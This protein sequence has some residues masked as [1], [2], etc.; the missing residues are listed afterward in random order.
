[1]VALL[2]RRCSNSNSD[3]HNNDTHSNTNSN[4]SDRITGRM[5]LAATW[6][7]AKLMMLHASGRE[8]GK[9]VLQQ[10]LVVHCIITTA[11][12]VTNRIRG[13]NCCCPLVEKV[14][15]MLDDTRP[16]ETKQGRNR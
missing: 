16:K 13:V 4:S 6:R 8:K 2:G 5:E 1:M 14:M 9:V 15:V 7:R 11:A 12:I 10:H 3:S